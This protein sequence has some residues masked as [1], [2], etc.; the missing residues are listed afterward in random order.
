MSGRNKLQF[1]GHVSM[2][3]AML[4]SIAV[5]Q[6]PRTS[7]VLVRLPCDLSEIRR[8]A[9]FRRVDAVLDFDGL[10]HTFISGT[11]CPSARSVEVVSG[12][13]LRGKKGRK[14]YNEIVLSARNS[15][16][17]KKYVVRFRGVILLK[18]GKY[19]E[20]VADLKSVDSSR[21]EVIAK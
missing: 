12:F 11:A 1:C 21:I 7:R 4:L 14:L 8:Q 2:I 18:S 13:S 6:S 3:S 20:I 5:G 19:G 10:D 17:G 15:E 9:G 16:P